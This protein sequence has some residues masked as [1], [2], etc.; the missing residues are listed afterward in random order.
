LLFIVGLGYD[1][2]PMPRHVFC[3]RCDANLGVLFERATE[4]GASLDF[5]PFDV[6][7]HVS[8]EQLVDELDALYRGESSLAVSLRRIEAPAAQLPV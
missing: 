2:P 5:R 7:W 4:N 1:R 6:C 8:R 3:N